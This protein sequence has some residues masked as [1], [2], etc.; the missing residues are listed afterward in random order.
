MLVYGKCEFFIMQMLYDCVLCDLTSWSW[1]KDHGNFII[2]E[3]EF[4]SR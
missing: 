3:R 4:N 2:Y 1:G